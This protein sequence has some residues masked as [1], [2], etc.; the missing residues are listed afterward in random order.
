MPEIS[1]LLLNSTFAT[2]PSKNRPQRVSKSSTIPLVT[3]YRK[4]LDTL[5]TILKDGFKIIQA[6]P[7]QKGVFN[8]M[9]IAIFKQPPNLKNMLVI[10]KS[11]IFKGIYFQYIYSI[12]FNYSTAMEM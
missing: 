11:L 5:N 1:K 6:S 2:A 3:T 7:S 4:R 10:P 8:E 9:P 12:I